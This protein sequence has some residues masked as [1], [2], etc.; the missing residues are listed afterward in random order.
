MLLGA[1][2]P[3]PRPA[4][5]LF[6]QVYSG[7]IHGSCR[8]YSGY[9]SVI[10]VSMIDALQKETNDKREQI[11]SEEEERIQK[12]ENDEIQRRQVDAEEEGY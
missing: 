1:N 9:L 8:V 4:N 11:L 10:E 5:L 6:I 3:E 2:T 12:L 7:R